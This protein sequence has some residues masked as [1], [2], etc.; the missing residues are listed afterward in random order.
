M[1]VEPRPTLRFAIGFCLAAAALLTLGFAHAEKTRR[2]LVAPL[3]GRYLARSATIVGTRTRRPASLD[4]FAWHTGDAVVDTDWRRTKADR[5]IYAGVDRDTTDQHGFL[6]TQGRPVFT[7]AYQIS[8][9]RID[10]HRQILNQVS[11]LAHG[12]FDLWRD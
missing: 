2:R 11:I 8:S 3:R 4:R 5:A 10:G 9:E 12:E 1:R 7:V 6:W